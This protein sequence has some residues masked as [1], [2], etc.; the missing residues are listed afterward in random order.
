M[1]DA[2]LE[3]LVVGRSNSRQL[4]D[5]VVPSVEDTVGRRHAEV[6]VGAQNDCYLVDLGSTNGTFVAQGKSWKRITQ[7]KVD[8]DDRIR[9]GEYETTIRKLLA[10]RRAAPVKAV[11]KIN[12]E[13]PPAG[14]GSK[15][16]PRRNVLTG[17]VE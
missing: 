2:P 8:M 11:A 17:E 15:R 6:T 4:P 13:P 5:L 10:L 3:V 9:L 1:K 16:K 12:A 14:A 7:A